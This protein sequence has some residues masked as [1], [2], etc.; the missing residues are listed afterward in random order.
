MVRSGQ[1][2]IVVNLDI[3]GIAAA[4]ENVALDQFDAPSR[5]ADRCAAR[6]RARTQEADAVALSSPFQC[7]RPARVFVTHARQPGLPPPVSPAAHEFSCEEFRRARR[8]DSPCEWPLSVPGRPDCPQR[9]R[10]LG[11]AMTFRLSTVIRVRTA[12]GGG[13]GPE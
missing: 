5:V 11:E 3:E 7:R 10:W 2:P 9:S 4:P 12:M 1:D 13:R 6:C 8:G